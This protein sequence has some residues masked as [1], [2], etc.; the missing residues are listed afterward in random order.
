MSRTLSIA[1]VVQKVRPQLHTLAEN[2][3]RFSEVQPSPDLLDLVIWNVVVSFVVSVVSNAAYDGILLC[4]QRKGR[5]E[6]SDLAQLQQELNMQVIVPSFA[7]TEAAGARIATLLQTQYSYPEE[8]AK[9]T[10]AEAVQLIVSQVD[11]NA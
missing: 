7:E 3:E 10:A 4:L 5:I 2:D 6:P 1:D 8:D 11:V 9:R